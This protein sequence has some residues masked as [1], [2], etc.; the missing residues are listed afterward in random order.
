MKSLY[1]STLCI[2][3]CLLKKKKLNNSNLGSILSNLRSSGSTTN[4]GTAEIDVK[5]G[6][7]DKQPINKTRV[8]H[9]M[10][11]KFSA[12]KT[13]KVFHSS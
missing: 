3:N 9:T 1:S 12:L 5:Y 13:G 8:S 10:F 6:T 4:F 2:L 7:F 11:K